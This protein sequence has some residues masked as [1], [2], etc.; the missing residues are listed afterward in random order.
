HPFAEQ[1]LAYRA[2]DREKRIGGLVL[3]VKGDFCHK[4]KRI[5]EKHGRADDYVEVSLDSPYRYNPLHNDLDAYS[6][7]YS[8]AT[9]MTNVFGRGKEPFWQ[10]ASTNRLKFVILL[11][12]VL[13]DYVTLAQFY[14]RVINR[15]KL[16][17]RIA[18]GE[19]RFG[20]N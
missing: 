1:L 19:G 20:T 5:L 13:D 11:F 12:K 2:Q 7:P 9:L 4:V 15:E 18:A 8:I 17:A 10:Q 6:L 16:R 14:E 3:E